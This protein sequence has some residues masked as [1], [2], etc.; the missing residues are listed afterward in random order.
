[1]KNKFVSILLLT[2]L[3]GCEAQDEYKTPKIVGDNSEVIK[4]HAVMKRAAEA[5]LPKLTA[6]VE[7]FT[8]KSGKIITLEWAN[9]QSG[10]MNDLAKEGEQFD[11]T[12]FGHFYY[13]R[14]AGF[15]AMVFWRSMITQTDNANA[16]ANAKNAREKYR[17]SVEKCQ[18]QINENPHVPTVTIH[19]SPKQKNPPYPGCLKVIVLD[20]PDENSDNKP[21]YI[22][23]TCP[24]ENVK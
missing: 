16:K 1:M 4:K 5:Y 10:I 18:Q 17:Q 8:K 23:W 19:A 21:L 24:K 14:A 13:C 12:I 22:E 2:T 7:N 11:S 20:S 3:L 15:D 6:A 9:E